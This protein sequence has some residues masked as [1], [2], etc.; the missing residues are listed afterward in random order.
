MLLCSF[1]SWHLGTPPNESFPTVTLRSL[2]EGPLHFLHHLRQ[3]HMQ[4][5]DWESTW[6]EGCLIL[7]AVLSNMASRKTIRMDRLMIIW[8]T[9]EA[10]NLHV[11]LQTCKRCMTRRLQ[12]TTSCYRPERPDQFFATLTILNPSNICIN[13][14]TCMLRICQVLQH[15]AAQDFSSESVAKPFAYKLWVASSLQSWSSMSKIN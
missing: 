11:Q 7:H 15:H 1:T 5:N 2:P 3:S 9:R 6:A 4:S 14:L 13:H 10:R 8:S 12:G